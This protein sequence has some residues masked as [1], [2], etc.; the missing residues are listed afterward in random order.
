VYVNVVQNFGY[1]CHFEKTAR[2][3]LLPKEGK[4]AQSGT[5]VIIFKIISPKKIAKKL[6]FLTENKAKFCKILIVTLIFEKHAIFS[7]K[8]GK[9]CK[10]L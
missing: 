6:A 7:P 8:N 4:I 2:C 5:D 10:K 9:N 1:F 3:K